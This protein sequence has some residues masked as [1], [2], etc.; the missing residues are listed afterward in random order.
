MLNFI[1]LPHRVINSNENVER[2][3]KAFCRLSRK[4]NNNKKKQYTKLLFDQQHATK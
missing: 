2:T 1:T 3:I 4:G